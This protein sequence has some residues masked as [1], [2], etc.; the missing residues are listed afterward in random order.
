[1]D[2]SC[3]VSTPVVFEIHRSLRAW[4]LL[5]KVK[6]NSFFSLWTF[7]SDRD[8]IIKLQVPTSQQAADIDDN[9]INLQVPTS[10]QAADIDDNTP[11]TVSWY[12]FSVL[13]RLNQHRPWPDVSL[14]ITFT[15]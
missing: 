5:R 11:M 12:F 13:R 6:T 9:T 8:G 7:I 4:A 14:P 1:M 15:V 3:R 10:Q 2:I